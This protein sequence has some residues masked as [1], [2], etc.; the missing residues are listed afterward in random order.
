MQVITDAAIE[1]AQRY[2]E[3]EIRFHILDPIIRLLGYPG[4]ENV[5]LI[6]EEKLEYPYV[7]IGRR[8]KRDLPLGFC[9]YRAGVKGARGSFI[10]EAKRGDAPIN[11]REVE[12]AH[13]YA[14]HAQVGANYFVLCNGSCIA[15]HATLSGPHVGPIVEIPLSQL[16]ERFHE[17]ENILSPTN[18]A[19]NCC[20][21]HDKKLKLAPGLASSVRIRSGLYKLLD[22]K[23]RFFS[24]EQD[25]TRLFEE[26]FTNNSQL[27]HQIELLKS[28]FELRVD[29][30]RVER[31]DD[32]KIVA[33]LAFG[34]ATVH[35]RQAMMILGINHVSF[36][37][38]REFISIDPE[39]PTIFE[40]LSD[41][42]VARGTLMPQLLGGDALLTADVQGNMFIKAALHFADGKFQGQYIAMSDQRFDFPGMM[43]L[44][45]K[46]DMAGK[47][48]LQPDF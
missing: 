21:V 13:S 7:H 6:L 11:A 42:K 10:V 44:L 8:S 1:A 38:R 29:D 15:V 34:G 35:N 2:N 12:Q 17:I 5:Y 37:T 30:G 18:L 48:D 28:T 24:N 26:I 3:S 22:C 27:E 20:V 19:R 9:D 45:V 32:G 43:P 14:A 46:M 33:H 25:V 23:L 4:A 39:E 40:S 31:Q 41:F 16:N 36:A 47:F